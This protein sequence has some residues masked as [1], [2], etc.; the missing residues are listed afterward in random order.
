MTPP[1]TTLTT[2]EIRALDPRTDCF[3]TGPPRLVLVGPP[4]TG[5]T[6]SLLDH[7]LLPALRSGVQPEQILACSFS[8]AAAQELRDRLCGQTGIDTHSARRVCSTIHSECRHLLVQAGLDVRLHETERSR[9]ADESWMERLSKPCEDLTEEAVRLWDQARHRFPDAAPDP[10]ER[11]RRVFRG[12]AEFECRFSLDQLV[13]ATEAYEAT[14]QILGRMD[15]TDWLIRC[16]EETPPR[17]RLLL[18]DEAQDLSALQHAVVAHWAD[19]ADQVVWIGDPDQSIYEFSAA[20]SG[21]LTEMIRAGTEARLLSQSWRVPVRQHRIARSIILRNRDRIDAPYRPSEKPGHVETVLEHRAIQIA[22]AAHEEG[23]RCLVLSRAAVGLGWI[24][25]I[26]SDRGVPFRR[27]RGGAA[28]MQSERTRILIASLDMIRRGEP[29]AAAAARILV[30]ELPAKT[31]EQKSTWFGTDPIS[32]RD[33]HKK[34]ALQRLQDAE[35]IGGMGMW[36]VADLSALGLRLGSVLDARGLVEAY[37]A[38]RRSVDSR[39]AALLRIAERYGYAGLLDEPVIVLTTMHAA[40]GREAKVVIV[41]NQCPRPVLLTT[42]RPAG[43]Q[44][45]RRVA[46]VAVTRSE[47]ELYVVNGFG[48]GFFDVVGVAVEK[49]A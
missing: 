35:R 3:P 17:R 2:E 25:D 6:R 10:R 18:I 46:Y 48:R 49:A 21:R 28:P 27:E 29:I 34:D 41:E 39:S 40:K 13:A 5:K 19:H 47:E 7:W 43:M 42:T 31:K 38:V 8:R 23:R 1:P 11:L 45:E 22:V 30:D 36:G 16:R 26:L 4:G 33:L 44:A 9:D 20:E 24:A 15:F 32:G 12:S 14:K 37:V